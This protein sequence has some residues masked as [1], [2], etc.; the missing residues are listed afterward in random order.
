MSRDA[1]IDTEYRRLASEWHG[2]QWSPM[3]AYAST[4]SVT[5]GLCA[6]IRHCLSG[7]SQLTRGEHETW[8]PALERFLGHV[9]PI[10]DQLPEED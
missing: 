1:I 8:R 3:Y 9:A 10:E 5:R 7:F 4:G 2:G 6:E